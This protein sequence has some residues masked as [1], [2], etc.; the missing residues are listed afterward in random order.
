MSINSCGENQL[1]GCQ[2][3]FPR[4]WL[5]V[6]VQNFVL[7]LMSHLQSKTH[8]SVFPWEDR[9]G[10]WQA[11]LFGY[12]ASVTYPSVRQASAGSAFVRHGGGLAM[13]HLKARKLCI[14][15]HR[16]L[17]QAY[18]FASRQPRVMWMLGW[19]LQCG[20][21]ECCSP[22]DVVWSPA[23]LMLPGCVIWGKLL[24]LSEPPFP[25]L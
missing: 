2:H 19:A 13:S 24:E 1:C 5:D 6:S 14:T 7:M 3:E 12:C 20:G 18:S 11:L 16:K 21:Q 22:N 8:T 15:L 4:H 10:W 17:W 25:H 23:A 9:E